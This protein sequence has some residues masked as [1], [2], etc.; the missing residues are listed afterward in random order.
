[1]ADDLGGTL[2]AVNRDWLFA[3]GVGNLE[4]D[5]WQT[6]DVIGV[7]VAQQDRA[8]CPKGES[9]AAPVDLGVLA[10]VEQNRLAAGSDQRR[11]KWPVW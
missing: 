10:A 8:G 7:E 11:G 9:R 6:G 2:R 5:T 1:M 4:E 3:T